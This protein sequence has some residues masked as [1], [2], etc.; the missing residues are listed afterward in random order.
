MRCNLEEL[1]L[2]VFANPDE[3][4]QCSI[5][6]ED[7]QSG[8]PTYDLD[9]KHVFHQDCLSPWLTVSGCCPLCRRIVVSRIAVAELVDRGRVASP[10]HRD[11]DG[12]GYV[13]AFWD[14][15]LTF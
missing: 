8:E 10:Y 6:L 15:G 4:H 3:A 14:N 1:Q 12:E 7:V 13:P 11:Y 5:C 9:C 2:T